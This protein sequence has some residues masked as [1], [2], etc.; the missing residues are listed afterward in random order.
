VAVIGCLQNRAHF[1]TWRPFAQAQLRQGMQRAGQV[2]PGAN[3]DHLPDRTP[4]C[5]SV[6]RT[7]EGI[8]LNRHPQWKALDSLGGPG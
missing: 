4:K 6:V 7:D 2:R 8:A 3:G 1:A 5:K